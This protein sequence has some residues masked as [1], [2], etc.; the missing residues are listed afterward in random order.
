M[1]NL[2][3][4]VPPAPEPTPAPAL[5]LTEETFVYVDQDT[6][7]IIGPVEWAPSGNVKPLKR[8]QDAEGRRRGETYLW[9][10]VR[11]VKKALNVGGRHRG[12]EAHRPLEEAIELSNK[13][14]YWDTPPTPKEAEP[15][16]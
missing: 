14:P 2:A 8:P 15:Q 11:S 3:N 13:E 1:D 10:S 4:P 7:S 16:L 6:R 5:E 9:G 12:E